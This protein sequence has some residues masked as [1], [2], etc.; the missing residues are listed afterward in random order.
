MLSSKLR[1]ILKLRSITP[2]QLGKAAG[3]SRPTMSRIMR[4]HIPSGETLA[5]IAEALE[6]SP[7]YLRGGYTLPAHLTEEDIM[8]LADLRCVPY[9]RLVR[10]M[11]ERGV[12]VGEMRELMN[13]MKK[14]D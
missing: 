1:T 3:I 7:G 2:A 14:K 9:L 8:T 6:V 4:G 5:R 10:E 13:I 12:T 11:A